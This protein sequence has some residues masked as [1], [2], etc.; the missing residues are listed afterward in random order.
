M[1]VG[2]IVS[3]LAALGCYN[4]GSQ[5]VR[6]SYLLIHLVSRKKRQFME[7]GPTSEYLDNFVVN[8]GRLFRALPK[9]VLV[10]RAVGSAEKVL[11]KGKA[12]HCM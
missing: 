6:C 12:W 8:D 3:V 1:E 4:G 9:H 5:F 10:R 11:S 2:C 7:S